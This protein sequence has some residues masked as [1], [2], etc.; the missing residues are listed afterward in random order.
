MLILPVHLGGDWT[1]LVTNADH[2]PSIASAACMIGTN[3]FNPSARIEN[4]LPNW[5]SAKPVEALKYQRSKN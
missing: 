5:A 4:I 3:A 1:N 2:V